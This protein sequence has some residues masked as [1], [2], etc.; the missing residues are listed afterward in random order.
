MALIGEKP[1]EDT[2]LQQKLDVI[3]VDIGKLGMYAAILIIHVLLLRS[4]I[5]GIQRREFDLF[6][7]EMAPGLTKAGL[8]DNAKNECTGRFWEYIKEWLGHIIV[9]VAIIVVAVPEGLPLAVMISLAYSVSKM[10][11]D[12]N[13]VKRLTSCE[14][15]GG[16]NNICSDKTGTLTKNQMTL[17][18]VWSG[19]DMKIPNVDG[20][21]P[22]DIEA[23][24]PAAFS[25]NLLNQAISCNS[26]GTDTDAQATELAMLKFIK[27]TGCDY[28][29]QRQQY[30]SKDMLRFQFDSLRKRMSTVLEFDVDDDENLEHGYPK[31]LHTKGAAEEIIKVCTHYL[32]EAGEKTELNDEIRS[33]LDD[34]IKGYAKDAL[35]CI[36]FS[37]MDLKEQL[38]GPT[39]ENKAENEEN[40][41][42]NLFEI[43]EKDHTLI[44][45]VGIKDIIRE[46]VPGA[47]AMCNE[48]GVRV[49]MITGDNILT[50]IAIAKEC[51]I[52]KEGEEFESNV[53]MLGQDFSNF[54]GGLVHKKTREDITVMGKEG[55]NEVIGNIENMKIIRKQLKV[56]ARS[57]PNDK[58]IMVKGLRDI[59]DIVAVTGDGT[60]DAP[61]LKKADVGFA[62]KTGTNV[63]HNAADIIIQ[64]DN[65]A[66][67]VKACKWGRNVY[68]N[69]RRFLQF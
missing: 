4:F 15:M 54:V 66:S 27:R 68:D 5:E 52:L 33:S 11:Q 39:H 24:I 14:I 34:I 20:D 32:N 9:G 28:Q 41:K 48:A 21:T 64:D 2:P 8:C 18:C 12:Q 58:Y 50:A 43:E 23:L 6:G 65:F 37:Y 67:I 40:S 38:G 61:A 1:Q 46:E 25:R 30:L 17:T 45:L 57:R 3:A 60:N 22:I 56:L 42:K 62:M 13:F 44:C 55:A 16:A 63:A 51:H 53:V 47:I 36:A 7:G 26:I 49:R 10:L 35:R 19:Q 69:I 31:R 29:H 59:G